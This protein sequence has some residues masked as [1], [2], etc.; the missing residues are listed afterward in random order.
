MAT[1]RIPG[2]GVSNILSFLKPS[3]FP[4]GVSKAFRDIGKNVVRDI[5]EDFYSD[6]L[7]L[8]PDVIFEKYGDIPDIVPYLYYLHPH[9]Y[10]VW[11]YQNNKELYKMLFI[12][13]T[14][15]GIDFFASCDEKII[16]GLPLA[17][18]LNNN[19]IHIIKQFKAVATNPKYYDTYIR[20]YQYMTFDEVVP[21]D[22]FSEQFYPMFDISESFDKIVDSFNTVHLRDYTEVNSF[23]YLFKN[24]RS[25]WRINKISATRLLNNYRSYSYTD[26]FL[27]GIKLGFTITEEMF[28]IFMDI[29]L[30]SRRYTTD[31]EEMKKFTHS[32]LI[33]ASTSIGWFCVTNCW[34]QITNVCGR[35]DNL[36]PLESIVS[37]HMSP[38]RI[39]ICDYLLLKGLTTKAQIQYI[40]ITQCVPSLIMSEDVKPSHITI[41]NETDPTEESATKMF[42]K[43]ITMPPT[44]NRN[45]CLKVLA[46]VCHDY[47]FPSL[48]VPLFNVGIESKQHS[49][50]ISEG[51]I[52]TIVSTERRNR[53]TFEK[54][55][56]DPAYTYTDAY[57]R[58]N[59][60]TAFT[61]NL[62]NV[63]WYDFNYGIP[64]LAVGYLLCL[65]GIK[66]MYP[67][68][69]KKLILLIERFMD[70]RYK[71]IQESDLYKF[72]PI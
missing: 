54:I 49:L 68:K 43:L 16:G 63:E 48:V 32:S 13:L 69:N 47:Y 37:I 17:W 18:M 64:S 34:K 51:D 33:S 14:K 26:D 72:V 6:L 61:A 27:E 11:I 20:A 65:K 12:S 19:H 9:E 24:R 35:E 39:A 25:D 52:L 53:Y 15:V 10:I 36:I 28:N 45:K 7:I 31:T 50:H 3:Q 8:D 71:L 23:L 29:I 67:I 56:I 41:Y 4:T 70:G 44:E 59:Y 22:R 42:E 1:P 21:S 66:F 38:E 62:L 5:K 55:K 40:A 60:V 30:K 57:E 2:V 58:R 46:N